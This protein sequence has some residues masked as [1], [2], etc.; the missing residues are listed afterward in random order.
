[1]FGKK[2][3]GKISSMQ[4]RM[5]NLT[6][7]RTKPK[8]LQ[9]NLT[10]KQNVYIPKHWDAMCLPK[11]WIYLILNYANLILWWCRYQTSNPCDSVSFKWSS[12]ERFW[13]GQHSNISGELR[14][15]SPGSRRVKPRNK[16]VNQTMS[17][18]YLRLNNTSM[19][20][21][22]TSMTAFKYILLRIMS[23]VTSIS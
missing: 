12:Q 21:K 3:R 8:G 9:H 11:N 17:H 2:S 23:T 15:V 19:S 6:N 22:G 10:I 4:T 14:Q 7:V 13:K 1:M 16:W 18:G 20:N 5:A